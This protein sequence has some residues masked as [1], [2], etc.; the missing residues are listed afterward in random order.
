[1]QHPVLCCFK[2]KRSALQAALDA[3]EA[4]CNARYHNYKVDIA[5]AT[6]LFMLIDVLVSALL[7][8]SSCGQVTADLIDSCNMAKDELE[9]ACEVLK[10]KK[11]KK[12]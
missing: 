10:T 9:K 1:M 5:C 4:G 3:D 11:A 12:A 2:A 6:W 8:I 7:S